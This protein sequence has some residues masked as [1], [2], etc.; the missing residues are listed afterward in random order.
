MARGDF[1]LLT[2][3]PVV[4]ILLDVGN[5]RIRNGQD[6]ADCI[7]RILRKEDQLLALMKDIAENGLTT[8]PILVKPVEDKLVVMDG[9]RRVTALKLLNDVNLCPVER[10]KPGIRALHSK[11]ENNLVSVVDVLSSNNDEAIAREVL[12]RHSGAQGGV[13]QL[14]WSAYLRTVYLLNH[15][16]PPDYK[17]AGQYALW[18]EKQG[19]WVDDDFPI[20]SLHRF[21]TAENLKRLGFDIC[22]DELVPCVPVDVAKRM[23][24][25][26]MTDFQGP[27]KVDDIRTPTLAEAYIDTVQNRNGVVTNSASPNAPL[28]SP[29]SNGSTSATSSNGTASAPSPQGT[30]A[31]GAI[32]SAPMPAS[33]P[34]P[35]TSPTPLTPAWQR[36]KVLG[37]RAPN[38]PI[39]DSETKARNVIAE[40]RKL[41]I[42]DTPM[43]GAMLLRGFIELST[44][45]YMGK[46]GLAFT[47]LG[48]S[49]VVAVNHM[50]AAGSVTLSEHDIV[51]RVADPGT[52]ATDLM[53][54][55][56]LQKVMHRGTHHTEYQFVNTLWDNV[57]P[58][59]RACWTK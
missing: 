49:V 59:V 2:D 30:P 18:T 25:T 32:P 12:A 4:D 14:D 36:K 48:K 29:A 7:E 37:S 34:S 55:E 44:N 50:H 1:T 10:L 16:H 40:L 5:P 26:L 42:Q 57:V 39:P 11:H 43:A 45:Y 27:V 28:Q 24:Q 17:R 56:T 13:G 31:G 35:A 21:F 38:I 52:S 19:I 54:I 58:F 51:K 47:T 23:A 33:A 8:M 53:H 46:H 20:S 22:N 9:N 3:I 6:Q 15:G 41:N